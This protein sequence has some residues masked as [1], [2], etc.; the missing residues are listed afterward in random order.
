MNSKDQRIKTA[1]E[2]P[3]IIEEEIK[4]PFRDRTVRHPLT[5][6]AMVRHTIY[7]GPQEDPEPT[8]ITVTNT[9]AEECERICRKQHWERA[10][11]FCEYYGPQSFAG[12][13]VEGDD[14]QLTVIDVAPYKQGFLP[15]TKFLKLFGAVGPDYLG[16]LKWNKELVE[17]VRRG[18]L[19]GA[20]QEG[21]VGKAQQGKKLLWFKTK[22]NWWRSEVKRLYSPEEADKILNS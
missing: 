14:M 2:T 6:A 17:S 8:E 7:Y 22:T 18:E 20:S 9:L 12:R 10:V 5:V 21:V 19:E 16:F 4:L 13:H 3:R 1:Q 11:V 15:P